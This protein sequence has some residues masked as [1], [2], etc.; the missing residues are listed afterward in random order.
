MPYIPKPPLLIVDDEPSVLESL[1]LIFEADFRIDAFKTAA[2]ALKAM[3]TRTYAVALVDIRLPGISGEDLLKALKDKWPLTEVVMI[4]AAPEKALAKRCYDAGAYD[5]VTKPYD[6]DSLLRTIRRAADKYELA[7]KYEILGRQLEQIKPMD[8]TAPR[9][10]SWDSI[11]KKVSKLVSAMVAFNARSPKEKLHKFGEVVNE[12]E[13]QAI[14][15]AMTL[16]NWNQL[17]SGSLL[18]LHRDTVSNKMKQ[19]KISSTKRP[20]GLKLKKKTK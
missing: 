8:P 6:N 5:F 1:K 2:K 3:K 16:T 17:R 13:R 12:M 19:Y 15:Q 7:R 18:G 11:L 10:G 14:L 4:T 20:K 9:P